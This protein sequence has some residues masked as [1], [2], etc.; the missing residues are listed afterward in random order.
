LTRCHMS[1]EEPGGC[2]R[3]IPFCIITAS[4]HNQARNIRPSTP[5]RAA[6]IPI[7]P[8]PCFRIRLSPISQHRIPSSLYP[9]LPHR[10]IPTHALYPTRH[11]F[12]RHGHAAFTRPTTSHPN[13]DPVLKTKRSTLSGSR[14]RLPRAIPLYYDAIR[15]DRSD[16]HPIVTGF[17]FLPYLCGP[18]FPIPVYPLECG[19]DLPPHLSKLYDIRLL[20]ELWAVLAAHGCLQSSPTYAHSVRFAYPHHLRLDI[21]IMEW[22]PRTMASPLRSPALSSVFD[23]IGPCGCG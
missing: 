8:H 18:S 11:H 16:P 14:L 2:T 6:P 9:A 10:P 7:P 5:S 19:L 22:D 15:D 13:D 12:L 4:L 3:H 1:F 20:P 17:A 21:R 23:P